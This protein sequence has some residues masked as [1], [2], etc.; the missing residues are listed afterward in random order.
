MEWRVETEKLAA[1]YEKSKRVV[2]N[3]A[4]LP[5]DG[6]NPDDFTREQR[7]GIMYWFAVLANFDASGPAVFAR[8]T[9]QAFEKHEEDP[10]RKCFFS[11]TRDEMNHEECCQ[12]TIAKLWPGGPLDWT[13]A[14]D[15]EAAAHNNIGWL[16][17]NGGRYWTGYTSAVGRYSLPVLFTSFMMGEMAASTLFRGMASGT[18]HPVFGEMFQRIGRDESRHLQ[19]CMTILETEWPGLTDAT[20]TLITRQ[21]RAG[22]VF[23]S[24]ILW[25]PPRAEAFSCCK[26]E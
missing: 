13:P 22:F 20:R 11:I 4:D 1:I 14:D 9:I 21:L 18:G 25:E 10:V 24:M 19:I 5:W 16:Y 2:W 23:L 7:L 12:R 15:L 17:H 6:L 8:A 3:P 26:T